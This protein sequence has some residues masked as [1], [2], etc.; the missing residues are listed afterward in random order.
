MPN[1]IDKGLD[2][3]KDFLQKLISPS[4]EEIGLLAADNI[5]FRRFKNQVRIIE[6]ASKYVTKKGIQIKGLPVKILVPLTEAA[7][8]E[9]NEDLQNKWVGLLVNYID[10]KKSHQSSIFP[11]ILSQISTDEAKCIDFMRFDGKYYTDYK[12]IPKELEI[13]DSELSNLTRLGLI[14]QAPQKIIMKEPS[15]DREGKFIQDASYDDNDL[16][17]ELTELGYEFVDACKLDQDEK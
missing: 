9:E 5:R 8:L 14:R 12:D 2:L 3:A 16:K 17:Y 6:K 4:V 7:S 11:Y 10:T 13:Y 1:A 15:L